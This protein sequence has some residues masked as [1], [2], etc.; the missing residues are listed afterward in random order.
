MALRHPRGVLKT[1]EEG[2]YWQA[3]NRDAYWY[4]N[5]VLAPQVLRPICLAL[6]E[7]GYPLIERPR[8]KLNDPPARAP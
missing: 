4:L 5:E 7:D 8:W 1:V 6:E 3:Y 2:T